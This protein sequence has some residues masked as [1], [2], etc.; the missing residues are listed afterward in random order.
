[1]RCQNGLSM[2]HASSRFSNVE[3]G[4]WLLSSMIQ[5]SQE[6]KKRASQLEWTP[7]WLNWARRLSEDFE[8]KCIYSENI[9]R[10]SAIALLLKQIH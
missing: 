7:A 3:D 10:I 4:L 1:M 6:R 9:I 5:A 8:Q 2:V